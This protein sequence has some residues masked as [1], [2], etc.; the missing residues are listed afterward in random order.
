MI[1]GSPAPRRADTAP[2]RAYVRPPSE[3]DIETVVE[4]EA[5]DPP[6]DA[7]E[8]GGHELIEICV[9]T[10]QA[11]VTETVLDTTMQTVVV[12]RTEPVSSRQ[13]TVV[14]ADDEPTTVRKPIPQSAAQPATR[15][16]GWDE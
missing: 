9:E 6:D 7:A 5:E 10:D 13:P 12:T 2:G 16:R 1:P 8:V 14:V 11:R 3:P 15:K 4:I